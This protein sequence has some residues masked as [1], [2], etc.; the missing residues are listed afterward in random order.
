MLMRLFEHIPK[1]PHEPY[2]TGLQRGTRALIKNKNKKEQ[3]W[4]QISALTLSYMSYL[5]FLSFSFL[6]NQT[7]TI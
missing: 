6:K 7:G 5:Y 3:T 2:E 4:T 1:R